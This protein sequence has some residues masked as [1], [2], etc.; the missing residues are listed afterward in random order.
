MSLGDSPGVCRQSLDPLGETKGQILHSLL[1]VGVLQANLSQGGQG[2]AFLVHITSLAVNN[3][4]QVKHL[5]GLLKVA[6][7]GIA[8]LSISL[9]LF[10]SLLPL[11][12]SGHLLDF[13][14]DNLSIFSLTLLLNLRLQL[15]VHFSWSHHVLQHY[16]FR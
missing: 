6:S 9:H 15:L 5:P 1:E 12:N 13:H 7:L 4:S 3:L 11:D 8:L 10:T 2:L 14:L 16:D